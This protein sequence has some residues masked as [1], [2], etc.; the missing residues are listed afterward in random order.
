[1]SLPTEDVV[2]AVLAVLARFGLSERLTDPF[3]LLDGWI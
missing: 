3:G 2:G 1:M